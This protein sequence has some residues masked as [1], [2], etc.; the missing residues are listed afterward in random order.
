M[1]LSEAIDLLDSPQLR[2]LKP[3]AAPVRWADLGCG[4]GLFTEALAQFLPRDST[5][6][7]VDLRPTLYSEVV[8]GVALFPIQADFIKIPLP[9][10]DLDGI[11]MANSYHYVEDKPA[12]LEK[13]KEY[14]KPGAPLLFVE[15]DSDRPVPT[16]VP[17]PV[18]FSSLQPLLGKAGWTSVQKL[19]ER[20]SVFGHSNLYAALATTLMNYTLRPAA[21]TDR[22]AIIGLY[23]K[24]IRLSGGLA[25]REEEVTPEYVNA[26]IEKSRADGLQFVATDG[27]QIIGEIHCYKS[28]IACFD[29]LLGELTI[30][31]D[32]DHQGRG[33]G[34]A[35]FM[36][37]MSEVKEN[38]K[39]ILRIE[40][41]TGELNKRAIAFY[42]SLGFVIEGRMP[43][44]Y[45]L[46]PADLA[47]LG[48]P[49]APDTFGPASTP[50]SFDADIP[51]AWI[52]PNFEQ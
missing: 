12:F 24:V 39:D 51:M 20:P 52:N 31:V 13:L 10:S 6:Y 41:L 45:K 19:A 21:S 32:P 40:L 48:A 49:P 28:G 46:G 26:F 22:E 35:L 9:F 37:V 11:L 4:N 7:G 18:S 14:L 29:H 5:I 47:R 16:W 38:R 17:W 44:R 3:A 25:R 36:A 42:Q 34:K 33:V 30:A 8:N 15:Y 43:N 27:T 1:R 23:K 50:A 2:A